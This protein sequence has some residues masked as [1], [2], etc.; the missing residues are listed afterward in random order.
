MVVD[1]R[2]DHE[3]YFVGARVAGL[4]RR[5]VLEYKAFKQSVLP[6]QIDDAESID[7]AG[8]S[9]RIAGELAWL[10]LVPRGES[11][12]P[13]QYVCITVRGQLYR[14]TIVL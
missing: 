6:H 4:I 8:R 10:K 9:Q 7:I 14:A 3:R 2:I 12:G 11:I 1:A 5:G 13:I